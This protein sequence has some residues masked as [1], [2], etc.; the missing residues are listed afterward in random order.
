[1]TGSTSTVSLLVMGHPEERCDRS[2]LYNESP[3]ELVKLTWPAVL[4]DT[5]FPKLNYT[6]EST[7]R[8]EKSLKVSSPAVAEVTTVTQTGCALSRTPENVLPAPQEATV[9]PAPTVCFELLHAPQRA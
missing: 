1:M 4:E 5:H 8:S 9:P 2:H 6:R 3:G 7:L